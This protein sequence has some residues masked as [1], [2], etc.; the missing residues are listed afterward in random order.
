MDGFAVLIEFLF[1]SGLVLTLLVSLLVILLTIIIKS[2]G[3]YK[4]VKQIVRVIAIIFAFFSFVILVFIYG[5]LSTKRRG[6]INEYSGIYKLKM[7]KC[8]DCED[9]FVELKPNRKY[10]V[11]SKGIKIDKGKWDVKFGEFYYYI[12]VENGDQQFYPDSTKTMHSIKNEDCQPYWRN[13]N[14]QDEIDGVIISVDSIPRP[15]YGVFPFKVKDKLTG[16]TIEY[17]P[18]YSGHP[19]LNKYLIEGNYISK[20]K[21]EMNFVIESKQEGIINIGEK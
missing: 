7:Y 10:V 12:N 1:I 11:T 2:K 15:V 6:A 19:W 4:V 3:K 14:L 20:K 8:E 17:K 21:G 9:C 5:T 16:D 13:K 18:R